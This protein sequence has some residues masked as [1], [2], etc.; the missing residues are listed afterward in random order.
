VVKKDDEKSFN[1]NEK[2]SVDFA[3]II[4]LSR[5]STR[6]REKRVSGLFWTLEKRFQATKTAQ[7]DSMDNAAKV[8]PELWATLI[9]I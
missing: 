1:R 6:E 2:D 4:D 5:D 8:N 9:L 7:N 3:R